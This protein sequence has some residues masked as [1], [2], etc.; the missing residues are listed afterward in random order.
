MELQESQLEGFLAAGKEFELGGLVQEEEEGFNVKIAEEEEGFNIKLTEEEGFNIK[1]P[2]YGSSNQPMDP[3]LETV[4]V[5]LET[6]SSFILDCPFCH[7][8]FKEMSDLNAHI[9][10]CSDPTI[11]QEEKF[12]NKTEAMASCEECA[13]APGNNKGA[14]MALERHKFK[15][16]GGNICKECDF[17]ATT[18]FEM[19]QHGIS[20]HIKGSVKCVECKKFFASANQLKA[21]AK[22]VHS[23]DIV[24]CPRCKVKF[25]NI[26]KLEFHLP[27]CTV[28]PCDL[29]EYG[30]QSESSLEQHKRFKHE[31]I[32]YYCDLC[33]YITGFES[34]LTMHT[35]SKHKNKKHGTHPCDQCKMKC[36]TPAG[37]ELHKQRIHSDERVI[38][39]GGVQDARGVIRFHCDLCD[40]ITTTNGNLMMHKKNK[41]LRI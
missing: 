11:N 40:Y 32:R 18:Y 14:K 29:C 38:P 20:A 2:D 33:T 22:V 37:L 15:V 36:I 17:K 13:F 10:S 27:V 5:K 4:D 28:F 34:Q 3:F 12:E 7:Q 30:A 25:G 23:P 8:S 35:Q 24:P 6:V 26:Q 19:N 9:V 16:H 41:H 1:M 31:G 21:H 39:N